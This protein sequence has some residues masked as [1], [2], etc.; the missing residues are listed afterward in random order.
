MFLIYEYNH[1]LYKNNE[2]NNRKGNDSYF[3]VV[4]QLHYI[5]MY[6]VIKLYT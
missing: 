5:I 2:N 4:S 3:K 6:L 1:K